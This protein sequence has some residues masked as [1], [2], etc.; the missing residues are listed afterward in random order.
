MKQ[1]HEL[2]ILRRFADDILAGKKTW[3][4]RYNDRDFKVGD[5][6]HFRVFEPVGCYYQDH[7]ITRRLYE[8]AYMLDEMDFRG[9]EYG[10]VVFTIREI[11]IGGDDERP[12]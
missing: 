7:E 3:E 1:L 5:V 6:I 12:D 4:I 10:Y 8:I 2:K 11:E 9:I